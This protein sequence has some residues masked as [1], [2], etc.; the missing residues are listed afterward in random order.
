MGSICGKL[1]SLWTVWIH[2]V[3]FPRLFPAINLYRK[4]ISSVIHLFREPTTTTSF[5]Y[6]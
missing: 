4:M 3:N 6:I 2:L 5:F 1:L